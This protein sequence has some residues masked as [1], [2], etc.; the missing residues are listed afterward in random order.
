MLVVVVVV[1]LVVGSESG[2][3]LTVVSRVVVV[4]SEWLEHPNTNA[5]LMRA[6]QRAMTGVIRFFIVVPHFAMA[7]EQTI[8]TC[9][10]TPNQQV[11]YLC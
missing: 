3:V 10:L 5:G 7:P 4:V 9:S 1:V 11:L 8:G 2:P 6:K